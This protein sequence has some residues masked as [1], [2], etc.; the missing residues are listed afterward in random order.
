MSEPLLTVQKHVAYINVPEELLMDAG[1][2]P[3]TRVH[4]PISRRTRLRWWVSGRR[5]AFAQLAYH[6]ISGDAFPEREDY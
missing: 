6:I 1:V 3:D 5:E 4:K 2:V